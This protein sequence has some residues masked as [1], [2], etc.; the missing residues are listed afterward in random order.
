MSFNF[1]GDKYQKASKHQKEWGTEIIA[2]L[3]LNGNEAILDLGCGDGVLTHHLAQLVPNG[4]VLGIDA[5]IGMIETAKQ[6]SGQNLS[7]ALMDIITIDFTNE[8]DIIFSNAALH[9]VKDHKSLLARCKKAL[10]L[11]GVIR[12]SFGGYGNCSNLNETLITAIEMPEYKKLFVGFEWPWY[13]PDKDEYAELVRCEG[14]R[15]CEISLDNADRHFANSEELIK[16][17]DQPCIVP[18][19]DY[20]G[21]EKTKNEFRYTVITKMLEKTLCNDNTYFETFRRMNLMAVK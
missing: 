3:K 18:F 2:E 7:F 14:F 16:W 10:K 15:E 17:I 9:W 13:M 19:L 1:D 11:N 5:S 21:K 8:F 12:W 6:K 4:K 20:I